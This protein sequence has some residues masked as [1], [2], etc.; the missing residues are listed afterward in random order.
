MQEE[1]KTDLLP[2]SNDYV[3]ARLFGRK[4][5]ERV[6]VCLLNAI[7]DGHPHIK[8]ITLDPTEHKKKR[9][10]GKTIRL[11]IAATS[12][13][14][15]RLNIEMQCHNEGNIADRAAYYQAR[16]REEELKE[17]QSYSTIPDI[18][19]IWICDEPVTKR[20]G[21]CHEIVDMY[22]KSPVDDSEIASEKVRQ[23]IIELTKIDMAEKCLLNKMFSVW[24][25]FIKD[26][27]TIPPEFLDYPE[28]NEA[29]SELTIMSADKI[30]RAEYNSRLKQLNDFRSGQTEK[31]NEG[32]HDKSLETA[33][34][35]FS[36]GLAI[37]Q[38]A[39]ATGLSLK[40]IEAIKI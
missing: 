31:Y 12:D 19:S 10:D 9:K 32:A 23:F 13:D 24:M 14:G 3:F 1:R 40:E 29:M 27:S 20:K 28:V 2:V 18:I 35:L 21:C 4:N 11:D 33:K 39:K 34:N 25:R 8:T 30:T 5:H 36:M 16:L 22:K 7:L 17:G 15:T 26:P 37:E 6:L 38:I